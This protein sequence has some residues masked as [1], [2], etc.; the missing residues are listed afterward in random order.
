MASHE[1][2]DIDTD[3]Q[4]INLEMVGPYL[5]AEV[6]TYIISSLLALKVSMASS[7]FLFQANIFLPLTLF[8]ID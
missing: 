4:T 1:N 7:F 5:L 6:L 8:A 2:Y 3:Y